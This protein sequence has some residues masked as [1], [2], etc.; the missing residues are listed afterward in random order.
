MEV[1]V[2]EHLGAL[3]DVAPHSSVQIPPAPPQDGLSGIF[4][5]FLCLPSSDL[6]F[7]DV[8]FFSA[9][10]RVFRLEFL[11]PHDKECELTVFGGFKS[12]PST[13]ICIFFEFIAT[14]KGH[15]VDSIVNMTNFPIICLCFSL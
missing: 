10:F 9:V 6:D 8:G 3:H 13:L 15:M 5:V 14:F 12:Y 1:A 4:F 7:C 11:G 2:E